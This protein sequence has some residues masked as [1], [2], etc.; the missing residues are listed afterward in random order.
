MLNELYHKIQTCHI[1]SQMDPTKS[2]RLLEAVSTNSDV[3]II[4][5]SLAEGQ[6]R[7]SG[8]NFFTENGVLGNTGKN[9]E[10]FLNKF[11]R[12]VFPHRD[13]LLQNGS[14]VKHNNYISVYNTEIAQCYPGK[15]IKGDRLPTKQEVSTCV[16]QN[17]LLEEI[18]LIKPKLL[19][20]M[21]RLS[22][23]NFFNNFLKILPPKPLTEYID[24]IEDILFIEPMNVHVLPIQHASGAN[25]RFGEM[26]NNEFLIEKIQA[27]LNP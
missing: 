24:T 26:I 6:L 27:I 5:Q 14:L 22:Y 17:F 15:G 21:G 19:L 7:R 9:L 8:V 16:N 2:L 18:K 23:E 20:L 4:S 13:I 25:P 1:C 12:T 10:K 3:F 11:N